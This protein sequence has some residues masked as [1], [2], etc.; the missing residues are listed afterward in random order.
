MAI[1]SESPPEVDDGV[2]DLQER[3]L[4]FLEDQ[5]SLP[6]IINDQVNALVVFYEKTRPEVD[7]VYLICLASEL[8]RMAAKIDKDRIEAAIAA[9]KS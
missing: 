2:T 3:V 6:T 4:G 8:R 5:T 9:A 1:R 7:E